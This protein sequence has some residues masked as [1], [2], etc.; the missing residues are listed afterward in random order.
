MPMTVNEPENISEFRLLKNITLNQ[1]EYNTIYSKKMDIILDTK[2]DT[3]S[4]KATMRMRKDGFIWFSMTAPLGIE[5]GRVLL[6]PDSV[7]FINSRDKTYFT[8]DYSYFSE[9]YGLELTFDCLQKVLSNRFFNLDVCISGERPVRKYKLDK[10]N[11]HYLLYTIEESSIDRQLKKL[12]KKRRKN[13][14][15]SLIMQKIEVDP[16]SFRPVSVSIEDLDEKVEFGVNY[17]DFKMFGDNFFPAKINFY[18]FSEED[19]SRLEIK[20]DR[21]EF[22]VPIESAFKI[23]VKYKK[24]K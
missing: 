4:F 3:K 18:I 23:P 14:E 17:G 1:L 8:S 6:T 13:K 2:G 12:Y 9:Q 20:I 24:V 16:L 21:L 19:K 10:N 5:I 11:G 15:F 7:K 22:D